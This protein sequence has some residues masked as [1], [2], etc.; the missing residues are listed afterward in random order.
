MNQS[1]SSGWEPVKDGGR[2]CT[3]SSKRRATL[4]LKPQSAPSFSS[5][6]FDNI[7]PVGS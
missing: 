7:Q 1:L 5:S 2:E 4:L 6:S 3:R